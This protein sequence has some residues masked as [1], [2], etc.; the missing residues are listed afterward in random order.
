MMDHPMADCRSLAIIP[1]QTDA[2]IIADICAAITKSQ[3]A[4]RRN[5]RGG[6]SNAR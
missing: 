2:A 6:N 1:K 4:N 3:P 5:D